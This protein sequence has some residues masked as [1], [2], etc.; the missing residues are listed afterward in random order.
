MSASNYLRD[1]QAS[2]VVDRCDLVVQGYLDKPAI[3]YGGNQASYNP[4]DD[5]IRIP[6]PE[7]FVS[8]EIFYGTLFHELIHSTGHESRLNRARYWHWKSRDDIAYQREELVAEV[9]ADYLCRFA[10][11]TRRRQRL[12]DCIGAV[13]DN[14]MARKAI[15]DAGKAFEYILTTP[16]AVEMALAVPA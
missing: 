13:P 1:A 6:L 9:G 8:F 14:D 2:R 4:C 3:R 11:I 12:C 7:G 10:K 15:D 5:I 16:I